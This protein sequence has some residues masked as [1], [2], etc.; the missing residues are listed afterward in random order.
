MSKMKF[1]YR[2]NETP[3]SKIEHT[4]LSIQHVFAMFGSTV[5][6]PTLIGLDVSVSLFTAGLGTLIY[7]MVTKKK[8]P[9]FIGSSFAYIGVLTALN[10][11]QGPVGVATAVISVGLIYVLIS[12]LIGKIGTKWLDTIL[13]AVVIGP[14]IIIIGLSLAPVAIQNSGLDA[15]STGPLNGII[16]LTALLSA[17]FAMLSKSTTTRT[18]PIII[19]IA[20]G[21][22]MAVVLGLLTGQNLVDTSQIFANGIF[23][24][25]RFNLPFISY[26]PTFNPGI[27]L[28]VL[29]LIL[30]TISEHI[31]DH[32]VSSSMMDEN[33]LHDP[34]LNKTL[35]GDGL[36]T[37]VAGLLGGPVNTTY[38]ENTGVIMLT[39]VASISVIR[40]A[41]VFAMAL[42]FLAPVVGFINSIPMSVMGGISILLFGMIAQNGIRIL[43]ES[44]L[45]FTHPR[46]LV[47]MSVI[48]VLGLGG[49]TVGFTLGDV[50]FSFTGMSLAILVGVIFHLILPQKEVAYGKK[51]T[52]I[53]HL[54]DELDELKEQ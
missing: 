44:N 28:S 20:A 49:A 37:I 54:V 32:S 9:V 7:S 17:T 11:D 53:D 30:V 47:I 33:Y 50:V 42:A 5:L 6:V 23:C 38:A 45:D 1:K 21:Y 51:H 27:V 3:E 24:V 52:N 35:R 41:A 18:V 40:L 2:V 43:V 14:V 4:V 46:N 39:R 10:Q 26:T 22:A 29:P 34:G 13:P 8:V 16:A 48:L 15:A 25:P 12:F 36:A 19:G 31:G